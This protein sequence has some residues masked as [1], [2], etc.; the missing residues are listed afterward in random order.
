MSKDSELSAE[1]AQT[2]ADSYAVTR[3]LATVFIF[4]IAIGLYD[5]SAF[6]LLL[7]LIAAFL[8]SYMLTLFLK[9]GAAATAAST[10]N[11]ETK[12]K[13]LLLPGDDKDAAKDAA[14]AAPAKVEEAAK[15]E[16]PKLPKAEPVNDAPLPVEIPATGKAPVDPNAEQLD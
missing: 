3:T 12:E 4:L 6:G 13:L 16:P 7:F 1:E 9:T 10:D 11:K 14:P 5:K 8:G 15:V 2:C